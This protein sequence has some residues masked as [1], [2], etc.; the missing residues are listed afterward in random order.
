M[1]DSKQA[2]DYK[3][4]SRLLKAAKTRDEEINTLKNDVININSELVKVNDTMDEIKNLLKG[5][6]NK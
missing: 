4:K 2:D 6:V 3:L 1:K 5:L